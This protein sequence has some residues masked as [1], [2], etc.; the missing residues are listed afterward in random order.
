MLVALG[1]VSILG[2]AALAT[3]YGLMVAKRNHL[4][5]T[6]DAAALAGAADLPN[7]A[8]AQYQA[9]MAARA[10][11]VYATTITYPNG[12]RQISVAASQRLNFFFGPFIGVPNGLVSA[13]ATADRVPLKGIPNVVPLA[14]TEDDYNANKDS[15]G[16]WEVLIDNNRQDFRNGTVAALDL[17][18]DNSAKSPSDFKDDLTNGTPNTVLIGQ[19]TNNALNASL[20]SQGAALKDAMEARINKAKLAPWHDTGSNYTFPNYPLGDPRIITIIVA[21][22]NLV[23]NNNPLLR[24]KYFAPVYVEQVMVKKISGE[25][26]ARLRFRILPSINFSS[27]DPQIVFGDATTPDTGLSAIRLSE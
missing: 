27:E 26:E 20:T 2:F 5:R 3:D 10:N 8:N 16:F 6:C 17:R 4:Q 15:G 22:P 25:T 7:I 11:G 12:V 24:A 18:N 1:L 23:D 14:I 21:D 19:Q 9:Q 13:R